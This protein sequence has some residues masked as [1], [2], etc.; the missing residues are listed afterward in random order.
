MDGPKDADTNSMMA[1]QKEINI[2][3]LLL[4]EDKVLF[5]D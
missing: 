1:S 2:G 3:L 5:D 4:I